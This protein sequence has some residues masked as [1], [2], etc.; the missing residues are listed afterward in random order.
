MS[1]PRIPLKPTPLEREVWDY[2]DVKLNTPK[3]E[4]GGLPIC[5]YVKRFRDSIIVCAPGE[6]LNDSLALWSK[7][8]DPDVHSAIVLAYPWPARGDDKNGRFTSRS[9]SRICDS[10]A[11]A[12]WDKDC[13]VLV[14]HPEDPY[15]VA[16]VWTGFDG[17]VL[18]ILQK[19]SLLKR[20]RAQLKKTDYYQGWSK[21]E[22]AAL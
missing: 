18:V 14:N 12:L 13:S 15:P 4:L 22:L 17:A 8:W 9:V 2:I 5:P 10:W 16:N 20:M 6:G 3:P 11:S 21:K 19:E 7:I 1:Q